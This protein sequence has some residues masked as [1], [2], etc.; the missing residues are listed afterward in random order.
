VTVYLVISLPKNTVNTPYIYFV[1]LANPMYLTFT[2]VHTSFKA[3]CG[4][5]TRHALMFGF[6]LVAQRRRHSQSN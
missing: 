4:H 3:V 1:V 6:G 5:R 2:H